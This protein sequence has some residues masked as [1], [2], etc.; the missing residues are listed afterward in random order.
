VIELRE[1]VGSS[2]ESLRHHALRSFLAMLGIIFGVGAVIAMLSIGAGAERQALEIID[3]M[4]LR[5]VVVRD[6]KIDRD[7][8]LQEIRRKSPG[9]RSRDARAI[10]DAIPGVERVV[11]KIEVEP[12]QV[13]SGSGK[14]KP[15][16]LGV[17][18]DYPTL[19]ALPI[20]EGRFF[21]RRDEETFAQ[22]CVIGDHVRRELFA[23]GPA[24]GQPVKVNDHWLTVVGVLAP[25]GGPR[26][27]EGVTVSSTA[28][29]VYLP[30]TTAE[31]K[32]ARA[33]LKSALDELVVSVAPGMP[34]Q[35]T[36][37]AIGSLLDR[38]HGGARDYTLTVPEALLEQ[39]Q[40][41]QRLFDVVM[42]AIAGISLLVG[43]IG[44][45]NIML[46]TVLERTREIG[47]RRAVG[48]RQVDIRNQFVAE[49]FL[50]SVTGGLLGI[51]M[52][53][54]IAEGVALYAGWKT[55]VTPFSI[56]LSSGV[57]IGVGLVF[58]IYP[59]T[60]AARLDPIDSLRYE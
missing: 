7:D 28:D 16:V 29:D 19:V 18:H 31:S 33:P 37:A 10:A 56:L 48:A 44:I 42:G 51:A 22:V 25:A 32:F 11:S 39:S 24:L 12:W 17:S 26:E 27:I 21:D 34:V 30:V 55:I 13:L 2:F 59:A 40:R 35:E 1:A 15:R 8:E 41:T 47:V 23:F 52:G 14:A 53:L 3:A 58:G 49:S 45:M 9:L 54:A 6:K 4:G 43:G 60:R 5:N 20:H 57:S 38:L 36:A 46:A 50:I